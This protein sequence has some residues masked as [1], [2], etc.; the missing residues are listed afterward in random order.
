MRWV[1]RTTQGEIPDE[2]MFVSFQSVEIP[3]R[4]LISMRH[5]YQ[6]A[7]T[8]RYSVSSIAK[9]AILMK[10]CSRRR[11]FSTLTISIVIL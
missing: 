1:S 2:R 9:R 4:A 8:I 6:C 5:E 10:T 3:Q 7:Y 11:S